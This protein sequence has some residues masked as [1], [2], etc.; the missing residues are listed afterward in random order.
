MRNWW[1]EADQD[2]FKARTSVL[3]EQYN[4]FEVLPGLYANGEF[5]LG[6][7]IGDLGG[8]SIAMKAYKLSMSGKAIPVIDGFSGEQRVLI[9]WAQAWLNKSREEALRL[10]VTTN[11]HSP[12]ILR[13]NGVVRNV[14]EF[15]TSFNVQE[16]D[17]LFLREDERVK[18]W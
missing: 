7:N 11:E 2:E 15:Y 8:L 12:A 14:P 6:E 16:Q 10:Q 1:T 13:V 18:I 9:G 5:T 17:S 3:I 4:E